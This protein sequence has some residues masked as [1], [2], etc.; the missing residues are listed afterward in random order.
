MSRLV[1]GRRVIAAL[2]EAGIA[3]EMTQ[4]VVLD[5]PVDGIPRVYLQKVGGPTLLDVAAVL[6]PDGVVTVV[7]EV[8]RTEDTESSGHD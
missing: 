3:D 6:T 2:I 4:R 8:D 7:S 5:I 1:H